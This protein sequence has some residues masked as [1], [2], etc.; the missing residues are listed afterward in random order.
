MIRH[1]LAPLSVSLL[2]VT[3]VPVVAG[4]SCVAPGS[5]TVIYHPSTPAT[6]C[7]TALTLVTGSSGPLICEARVAL[8]K[9]SQTSGDNRSYWGLRID[10]PSEEPLTLTLRFVDAPKGEAYG[11]KWGRVTVTRGD[12]LIFSRDY[13]CFAALKGRY[14]SLGFR[15]ETDG[16][17]TV[18]GGGTVAVPLFTIPTSPAPSEASI[19]LFN[20][21]CGQVSLFAAGSDTREGHPVMTGHSP[22]SLS[23]HFA[24]SADQLEGFWKYFDRQNDPDYARPG[25]AYTLAVVRNPD[26]DSYD[27]V[28]VD[29]AEI[30]S[31]KWKPMM[32]KGTLRRAA[33]IGHYDLKWIDATFRPIESDLHAILEEGSLLTLS[34]PLYKTTLRFA[35]LPN[36][37]PSL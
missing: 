11:K 18:S 6:L 3:S 2:L 7:D 31:S 13:D 9:V 1:L 30:H 19:S 22:E 10:S 12:S 8:E 33:F 17:L 15:L 16:N 21:G 28:L 24:T 23:R 34:F 4:P 26:T 5:D 32:L 37:Q 27:I 14:N 36:L 35:K 25:G 20:A 29:G